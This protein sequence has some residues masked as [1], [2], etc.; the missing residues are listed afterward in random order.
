MSENQDEEIK[1]PIAKTPEKI[2]K[3][4][5]A[6]QNEPKSE[7]DILISPSKDIMANDENNLEIPEYK[8]IKV[9]KS[10]SHKV[11]IAHPRKEK[12]VFC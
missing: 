2:H 9:V 10:Q 8:G 1:Q 3:I 5:S 12:D 11:N 4:E 7:L 6:H